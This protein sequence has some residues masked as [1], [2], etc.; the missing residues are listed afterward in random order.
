MADWAG[1]VHVESE[2]A[3]EP[4]RLFRESVRVMRAKIAVVRAAAQRLA[5]GGPEGADGDVSMADA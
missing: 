2:S 1:A 4:E 3:Y 5:A